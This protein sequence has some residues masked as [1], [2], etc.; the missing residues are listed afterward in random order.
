MMLWVKG[1]ERV[2]EK[3]SF[4]KRKGWL[5][6]IENYYKNFVVYTSCVFDSPGICNFC[7]LFSY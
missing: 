7:F 5:K 2:R 1:V 3:S 4:K 6:E